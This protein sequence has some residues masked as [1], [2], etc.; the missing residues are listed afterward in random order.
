MALIE[1]KIL[2]E[3]YEVD[4]RLA[5]MGL[6]RSGLLKVRDGALGAAADVTPIHCANAPGTFSYHIGVYMLRDQYLGEVWKMARPNGVEVIRNEAT[7]ILVGFS[8]VDVACDDENA[9]EP[10]SEKGAG[11]ERVEQ[12]AGLFGDLPRYAEKPESDAWAM[13][14]LMVD[15]N[16]RAE[17]SRP[18]IKDK[19]YSGFIERL[20]LSNGDD[21]GGQGLR[22][23]GE[24]ADGFDPQVV[25]KA[26]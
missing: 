3:P 15:H 7:R 20:Y 19:T 16:G 10:R 21:L 25:R 4:L 22:L 26:G 13:Y 24:I 18:V 11:A 9:P 14:Y 2:R 5:Q 1:T 23:D 8:N 12:C 6:T 17:L